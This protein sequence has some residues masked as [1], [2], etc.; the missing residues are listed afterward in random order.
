VAELPWEWLAAPDAQPFALAPGIRLVR[1]VPVSSPPPP[2][3]ASLPIRILLVLTNP[4]DERL[5]DPAREESVIRQGL[6][7]G[8]YDLRV[9]RDANLQSLRRVI[10]EHLPHVVHYA[11][12]AGI[13][14]G[15][16]NLVLHDESDQ[17][18]WL[19]TSSLAQILPASVRL[20][21]LSSCFTAENYELSGLS[22]IAFADAAS[23]CLPTTVVNHLQPRDEKAV[24]AFWA[25]FY[26]ALVKRAGDT[27]E[28]FHAAQVQ[29]AQTGSGDWGTFALVIRDSTGDGLRLA[30]DKGPVFEGVPGPGFHAAEIQAQFAA[31]LVNDLEAQKRLLGDSAPPWIQER[32]RVEQERAS[33][34][35][36]EA[37]GDQ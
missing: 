5:G 29:A 19:D 28:A 6:T 35:Q 36:R 11:G 1:T 26:A 4:K 13:S 30:H 7:G 15:Q 32:L 10:A 8:D 25:A 17:T 37:A 9:C 20:L 12:H 18:R 14:H 3:T 34:L 31:R 24:G 23:C 22:R 33:R 16:G 2:M 27:T 21:C